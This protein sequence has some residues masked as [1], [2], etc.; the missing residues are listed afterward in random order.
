MCEEGNSLCRGLAGAS[1]IVSR[2]S[3]VWRSAIGSA[4]VQTV[5]GSDIAERIQDRLYVVVGG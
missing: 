4:R 1:R 3:E 2:E 5:M